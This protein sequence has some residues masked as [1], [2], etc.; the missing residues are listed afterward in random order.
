MK[1]ITDTAIPDF[2][3][4]ADES[5]GD[6]KGLTQAQTVLARL[7]DLLLSSEIK[8]GTRLRAA[9]LADQLGVSRTPIRNALAVLE[10]EGLV[11]YSSNC[12]YTAREFGLQDI[13]DAIEVRAELEAMGARILAVNGLAEEVRE[14]VTQEVKTGREILSRQ[15]WTVENETDWYKCNYNFHR[16]LVYATNNKYLKNTIEATLVVPA[17]GDSLRFSATTVKAREHDTPPPESVPSHIVESQLHHERL[18]QAI[19]EHDAI[20]AHNIMREHILLSRER[21]KHMV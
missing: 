13:L 12:G 10:S 8:A 17:L 3:L 9:A 19:V 18:L 20:R 21:I 14:F 7:R 4:D 2:A 16:A 1:S 15:P 5:I 11:D 6:S